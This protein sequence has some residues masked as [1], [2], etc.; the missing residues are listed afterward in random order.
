MLF[1]KLDVPIYK[2]EGEG[3]LGGG[4]GGGG[5]VYSTSITC[6]RDH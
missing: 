2:G 3:V 6:T 1:L 4:G 5:G